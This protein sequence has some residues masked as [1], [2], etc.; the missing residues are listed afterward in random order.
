MAGQAS[1]RGRSG[2]R[3]MIA[4]INITPLC[5]ILLVLL[6]IFMVASTVIVSQA[7]KVELPKAK[8]S[9]GTSQG[10]ATLTLQRNGDIRWNGERVTE[11]ET[12]RGLHEAVAAD[13]KVELLISADKEVM[14]GRVVHFIDLAKQAG[15]LK[16]AI[17]VERGE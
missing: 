9:D 10:P 2:R 11:D 15:V 5:D 13:P 8:M 16:F 1:A 4:A 3:G 6:I 14:H 12:L 7:L 17:N